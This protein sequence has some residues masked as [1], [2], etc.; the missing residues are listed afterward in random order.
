MT[1]STPPEYYFPGIEFNPDFFEDVSSTLT[2]KECDAR[3]L[4]KTEQDT[5]TATETFTGGIK[6]NSIESV[7]DTNTL[8]IQTDSSTATNIVNV[9]NATTNNQ[10][11]NLNSKTINVGDTSVPSAINIISPSTFTGTATFSGPCNATRLNTETAGTAVFT[12]NVVCPKF[13]AG[14]GPTTQLDL[15]DT[16]VSGVANI[17]CNPT[18]TAAINICTTKNTS[19]AQS[20]NI[21]SSNASA[22]GQKININRPLT[23]GYPLS[24]ATTF[25]EIGYTTVYPVPPTVTTFPLTSTTKSTI[26]TITSLEIGIYMISMGVNCV[27]STTNGGS[28]CDVDKFEFGLTTNVATDVYLPCLG[29]KNSTLNTFNQ[30]GATNNNIFNCSG[31]L[32]NTAITTYYYTILATFDK[33]INVNP[34]INITRIG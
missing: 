33:V 24:A 9:G 22:T 13:N 31:I 3:Y 26:Q 17:C 21:G 7:I 16:Q 15:C 14:G 23:I 25:F 4:I 11:L 10:T 6:T 30:F 20:I 29:Y 28:H 5:A 34:F 19:S 18:R 27:Y 8:N 2:K 32:K 1:T 12:V